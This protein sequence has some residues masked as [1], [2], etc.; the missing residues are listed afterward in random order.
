MKMNKNMSVEPLVA[1]CTKTKLHIY[2]STEDPEIVFV[3]EH[4]T[5]EDFH[6]LVRSAV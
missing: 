2:S 3:F 5:A 1:N 4:R 6:L